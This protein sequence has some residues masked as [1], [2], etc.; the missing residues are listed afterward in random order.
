MTQEK[1]PHRKE[2]CL[3]SEQRG[4]HHAVLFETP[5]PFY[6]PLLTCNASVISLFSFWT[7]LPRWLRWPEVLPDTAPK[8]CCPRSSLHSWKN[9]HCL[10]WNCC[11]RNH[12]NHFRRSCSRSHWNYFRWN[13]YRSRWSC[14]HWNRCCRYWYWNHFHCFRCWNCH[15]SA[16]RCCCRF[17]YPGCHC[18]PD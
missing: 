7:R 11:C 13:R 18:P 12:S 16:H 2:L 17:R 6:V 5:K 15:H 10:C 14:F 3:Q 8:G 4:F 1:L 9:R